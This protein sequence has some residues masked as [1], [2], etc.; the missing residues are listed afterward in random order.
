[1]FVLIGFLVGVGF[2]VGDVGGREG[3]IWF[4]VGL[5]TCEEGTRWCGG[6]DSK[7]R[8]EGWGCMCGRVGDRCI[9]MIL[10]RDMTLRGEG[11]ELALVTGKPRS[12]GHQTLRQVTFQ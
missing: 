8:V 3:G 12:R 5:V 9:T 7:I 10:R 11:C 6:M 1:M 2:G 4:R